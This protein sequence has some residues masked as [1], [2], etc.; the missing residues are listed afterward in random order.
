ML[1]GRALPTLSIVSARPCSPHR[2]LLP[3]TAFGGE[4]SAEMTRRLLWGSHTDAAQNPP[5]EAKCLLPGAG[6]EIIFQGE[7]TNMNKKGIAFAGWMVLMLAAAPCLAAR[8]G[9]VTAS[10]NMGSGFAT[11]IQNTV[12]GVGL[13]SLSL[14]ATHAGTIPSNSW[15]STVGTLTGTVTF[16]FGATFLVGSFSFWNQNGGGPGGGGSTGIQGVAVSTSTDGVTF[17]PLAGGPA[18]FAQVPGVNAPPQIFNFTPVNARFFQFTILSNYG[19]PNETGFAEVGF[20]G[21]AGAIPTLSQWGLLLLAIVLC[22]F[23][24]LYLRKY[25]VAGRPASREPLG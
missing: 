18:T 14:T 11:N 15:V 13:S 21:N 20:D 22:G 6:V 23:A 25:A 2:L 4:R 7:G 5:D 17:T 12:N 8:L 1:R 16:D 19:D 9:A 24:A 10:T 3:N